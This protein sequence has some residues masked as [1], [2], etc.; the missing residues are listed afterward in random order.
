MGDGVFAGAGAADR[1]LA[2]LR[3]VAPRA[4]IALSPDPSLRRHLL[5]ATRT[6]LGPCDLLLGRH[7]L[8]AAQLVDLLQNLLDL[9]L[10]QNEL[11]ALVR[12]LRSGQ[13]RVILRPLVFRNEVVQANERLFVAV[14]FVDHG[15]EAGAH[16]SS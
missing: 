13:Q 2:L 10:F 8:P 5:P 1:R 6:A 9:G 3:L 16:A 15:L 14:P 4:D 12:A 11:L 7:N